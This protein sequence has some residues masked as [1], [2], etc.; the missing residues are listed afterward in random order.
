VGEYGNCLKFTIRHSSREPNPV[1]MHLAV[2]VLDHCR[3][4]WGITLNAGVYLLENA[5]SLPR[6]RTAARA[7]ITA[8]FQISSS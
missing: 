4:S 8:Q 3:G 5:F 6:D 2:G 7:N 1:A